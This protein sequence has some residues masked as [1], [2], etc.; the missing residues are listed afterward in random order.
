MPII[1]SY[2]YTTV[3]KQKNIPYYKPLIKSLE[4]KDQEGHLKKNTA[5]NF[6]I[7]TLQGI[8]NNFILY[9]L[10]NVS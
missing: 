6:E 8:N 5:M 2:S 9:L 3:N 4:K 7:Y 10:K 1:L